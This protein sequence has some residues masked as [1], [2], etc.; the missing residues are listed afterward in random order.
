MRAPPEEASTRARHRKTPN[1]GH[2]RERRPRARGRAAARR[3]R[4]RRRPRGHR[5][6]RPRRD[7]APRRGRR[8][9]GPG[10][11]RRP[12]RRRRAGSGGGRGR[13]PLGRHRRPGEQRRLR[14][15]RAVPRQHLRSL[16]PDAGAQRHR[17]RHGLQGR[18][19]GDARPALGP[20]RQH[21]LAGLAHG[22]ARLHRLHR[23][24]GRRRRDH[25]RRRGGAGALR[26]PRQRPR[27]RDDGHRDA[28]LDR[29][30]AGAGLRPAG[31][32]GLPRRAHP[33]R[34]A[35]PAG[36]DRRGRR[37]GGLARSSTRPPT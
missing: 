31:S 3:A 15:D 27:P 1:P 17:P 13:R 32:P 26:R 20:D 23:Q 16:D 18:G 36:R 30:R 5:R 34:A 6:R 24:Q 10:D 21:H 7:R 35:R 28:A 9:R 11:R 19:P 22:A 37:L 4:L 12:H 33:A 14:G 29:G 8:R 25:P 2:R